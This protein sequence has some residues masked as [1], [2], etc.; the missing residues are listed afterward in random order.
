MKVKEESKK[1]GLK[2]NIHKMKIMASSPIT[3]WQ[4]FGEIV[5]DFIFLGSKITKDGYCSHE[6]KRCSLEGKLQRTETAYWDIILPTKVHN[7]QH[8]GFSSSHVQIAELDHKAG[9]APKNWC[10]W[11]VVLEK[12]LESPLDCMEI[13]PVNSEHSFEGLMLKLKLQYF[14]NLL[15]RTDSLE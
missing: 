14:G 12:M 13:K 15:W 3:S 2:L 11:T 9:W 1:F 4:T 8:Y 6:I 7:R 10:F 5:T